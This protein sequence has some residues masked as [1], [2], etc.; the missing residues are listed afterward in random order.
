MRRCLPPPEA[1]L[2]ADELSVLQEAVT[3]YGQGRPKLLICVAGKAHVVHDDDATLAKRGHSPAQLED[4]PAG[5]VREDQV[6][7]AEPADTRR[8][9]DL[10]GA[11][12]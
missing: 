10:R 11:L 7:L 4:L 3:H 9:G 6:K 2:G 5:R 8:L 12:R 1:Q